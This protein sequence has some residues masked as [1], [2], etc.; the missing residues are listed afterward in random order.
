M[1]LLDGLRFHTFLGI[2]GSRYDALMPLDRPVLVTGT[3]RSGKTQIWR[4]LSAS[5]EFAAIQEPLLLWDA[6]SASDDDRLTSAD[7][8]PQ[9]SERIRL[10]CK[11]AVDSRQMPRYLDNLSH[12]AIRLT[13]VHSVMPKAKIIHVI[14]DPNDVLPELKFGWTNRDT[15]RKAVARRTGQGRYLTALRHIPRF[16]QNYVVSRAKGR[17]QTYGPRVPG[18]L[19]FSRGKTAAEV[20]AHQWAIMVT[21]ALDDALL[22][23]PGTIMHIRFEDL[24]EK[25]NET[26]LKI[27][28]FAEAANPSASAEW[29]TRTLRDDYVHYEPNAVSLTSDEWDQ[30]TRF[31]SPVRE[32]ISKV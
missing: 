14:R 23:P 19:D 11:R 15:V 32:R 28:Q 4:L 18:Y 9:V 12:H 3:P 16:A 6:S 5:G 1:E 27:A 17:R 25:T 29:A 30:V 31:V 13:F 21:I 10:A 8:T 24:I 20:A 26:A 22:L 2:L 7:S